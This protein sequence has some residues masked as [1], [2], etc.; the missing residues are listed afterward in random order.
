MFENFN[1]GYHAN[2]LHQ[3]VQDFCPSSMTAFPVAVGRRLQRHLPHRRLHPPRR[4]LQRHPPGD[5]AGVPEAHRGGALALDVRPRAPDAVLRHRSRP[6]LLL[7][8]APDRAA[9][10]ST[11]RSATSSTRRRSTTRCSSTSCKLSDVGVQVFVRQDQDAT[12]KVQRGLRSR[13]ARAAATPGR[14]RATCS[15]TAGS[16]SAIAGIGRRRR[17]RRTIVGGMV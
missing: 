10:R 15:S 7:P 5:H 1:D 12:T 17:R 2:R 4:R 8:R 11:S 13:F 6:V 3:Y 9:R 14:R 16:C